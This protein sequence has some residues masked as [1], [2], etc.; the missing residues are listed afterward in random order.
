MSRRSARDLVLTDGTAATLAPAVSRR[1]YVGGIA[2][3]VLL[4][5]GASIASSQ[6]VGSRVGNGGPAPIVKG[7]VRFTVLDRHLIR[8]QE[9]GADG[10]FADAQTL[11]AQR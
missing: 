7:N 9:R 10:R 8:M 4:V 6:N 5:L 3:L 11:F 1:A 2:S